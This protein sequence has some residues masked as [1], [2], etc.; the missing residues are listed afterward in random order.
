MAIHSLFHRSRRALAV[1]AVLCAVAAPAFA[2]SLEE[3][4][5][6]GLVGERLDGYLGLVAANP[7]AAVRDLV[8]EINRKRRQEYHEIAK[9]NQTSLDAVQVLA[10]KK[11]IE[12]T[13]PGRYVQLPSGEWTRKK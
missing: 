5:S 10:G 12:K 4:K 6:Q 13:A 2:V 11:A 3:A 1:V 9:R 7:P 8:A